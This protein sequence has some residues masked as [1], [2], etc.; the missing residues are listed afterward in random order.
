MADMTGVTYQQARKYERE[1]NRI[2]AGRLDEIARVL[3]L[4]ITY[5]FEGLEDG[6]S[7]NASNPR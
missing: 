7:E 3:S 1:I 4:P 2:S 5:F 6:G